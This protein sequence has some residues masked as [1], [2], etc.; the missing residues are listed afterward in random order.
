MITIHKQIKDAIKVLKAG[1][2]VAY[3]T[4]TVY[5]IGANIFIDK[6]VKTVFDIKQRPYDKALPI[7]LSS[8]DY[9]CIVADNISDIAWQ[10]AESFW[11]GALTLIFK[12][13]SSIS[14]YACAQGDSIAVRIPNHPVPLALISGL[15]VPITGTSANISGQESPV[16]AK[17]VY[18]QIGDRADIIIDGG[19]CPGAVESTIVDMTETIPRIVREGAISRTTIENI[20]GIHCI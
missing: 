18:R 17:E 2:I 4:D 14:T 1:G 5:G 6:A 12:K 8:K 10:L 9:L 13:K 7:L 16:T 20:C 19:L 11:P 15:G 3:P